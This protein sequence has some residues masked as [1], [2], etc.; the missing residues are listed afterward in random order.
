[1]HLSDL[2]KQYVNIKRPIKINYLSFN[3]LVNQLNDKN[4][5]TNFYNKDA[6][7]S[8][9]EKIRLEYELMECLRLFIYKR[10]SP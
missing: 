3:Q 8:V 10:L 6:P 7:K 9:K 1:M 4:I 2:F 5:R